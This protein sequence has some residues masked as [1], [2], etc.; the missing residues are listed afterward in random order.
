M[1]R[2]ARGD[3]DG[4]W[5]NAADVLARAAARSPDGAALVHAGS[6]LTWL[7]LD[8]RATAFARG[9]LSRGLRRGDRVVV[10]TA[11]RTEF[12]VAHY[13]AMRAGLI[14]VPMNPSLTAPELAARTHE[15]A[16][17][18]VVCDAT[19]EV[20][21]REALVTNRIGTEVVVPVG[22]AAWGDLMRPEHP[23]AEPRETDAES[24]AMLMLTS[25]TGGRVHAAM[26]S[27]RALLASVEQLG[28]L[29]PAPI[30][31]GDVLLLAQPLVHSYALNGLLALAVSAGATV[32]LERRFDADEA[33]DVLGRESVT[34]AA[35]AP[36]MFAE[37]AVRA[38]AAEALRDI[39]LLSLGPAPLPPAVAG[40]LLTLTGRPVWNGYGIVEATALVCCTAE[41]EVAAGSV[42][43]PLPGLELR[44]LDHDDD[45]VDEGDPGEVV[46]RGAT[47]FSGYWPD[48]G[49]GP[50]EWF[51]T[52]DV[53][54]RD[55]DG[56]LHLVDR[57]HDLIVV[58]GF[59]VYPREVEA[60]IASMPGVEQVRV[61][62]VDH[63]IDGHAVMARVVPS[64]GV[65][66][67]PADVIAHCAAR[68]ARFKRPT[69]V[70]VVP[71]MPPE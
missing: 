67:T 30:D 50:G 53:A 15:V 44:L 11:N 8:A 60:V 63:P 62:G 5:S 47:L 71:E 21:V 2:N 27:H 58:N 48:G 18:L 13:G 35:G 29:D 14:S 51:D 66:L 34:V 46:I 25:G 49:R 37:W 23:A 6:S 59:P 1:E 55:D 31:S 57:R 40:Q 70:D 61:V 28:R 3:S 69:I 12:I 54:Y 19:S 32:V 26:I 4:S 43:T 10:I 45:E 38:D 56:D 20:A 7:T 64:A 17:V 68:L 52:Q 22:S 16:P 42:G 9:A 24:I 65:D 41:R 39:R 33:F 36:T